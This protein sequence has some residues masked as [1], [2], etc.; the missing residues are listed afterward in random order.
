[1]N[2]ADV[3]KSL[4]DLGRSYVL[5]PANG[6]RLSVFLV[7]TYLG[8]QGVKL[9]SPWIRFEFTLLGADSV[10]GAIVVVI[11]T[12]ALIIAQYLKD[13]SG[14]LFLNAFRETLRLRELGFSLKE[15]ESQRFLEPYLI[16]AIYD[17]AERHST[18]IPV[19]DWTVSKLR[20]VVGGEEFS[21]LLIKTVPNMV[22]PEST[23]GTFIENWLLDDTF[24]EQFETIDHITAWITKETKKQ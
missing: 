12:M 22:G 8:L 18:P 24:K 2:V 4:L 23:V 16:S 9:I 14:Q 13:R 20:S 17:A 19:R 5:K 6:Y 15:I 1:M 7:V 11:V 10:P 21:S 3:L